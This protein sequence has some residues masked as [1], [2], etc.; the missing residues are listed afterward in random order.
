[1][2]RLTVVDEA[3]DTDLGLIGKKQEDIRDVLHRVRIFE[4]MNDEEIQQV[5]RIVHSRSFLPKE[6][7]VHQPLE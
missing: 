2:N 3:W 1:M 7:V 5:Q 4:S 6:V